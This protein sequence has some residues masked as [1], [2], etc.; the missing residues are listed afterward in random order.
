MDIN[1]THE[2]V[3]YLIA[4]EYVCNA[5]K[6]THETFWVKIECVVRVIPIHM[7]S[8]Y[9]YIY[10]GENIISSL[11][12]SVSRQQQ[13]G[14]AYQNDTN[15]QIDG[16]YSGMKCQYN[17]GRQSITDSKSGQDS[18]QADVI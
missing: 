11:L 2:H 7:L 10:L 9:S 3:S 13:Q 5:R 1:S 12:E 15:Q 16:D 18:R 8:Q 6:S 17:Q 14:I 4:D